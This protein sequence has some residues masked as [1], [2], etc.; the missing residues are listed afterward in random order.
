MFYMVVALI[1]LG[2]AII[3]AIILAL[4]D[5]IPSNSSISLV[6]INLDNTDVELS[7]ALEH[8]QR[9]NGVM[10]GYDEER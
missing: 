10:E 5:K 1:S 8:L 9:C 6:T 7:K 3:A 2:V 4:R